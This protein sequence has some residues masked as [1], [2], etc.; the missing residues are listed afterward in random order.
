MVTAERGPVQL[1]GKVAV[2]TGAGSGI[3]A[4]TAM[5]LAALGA[6]VCCAGRTVENVEQTAEKI[7]AGGGEAF[8]LR[9]DVTS[10]ADNDEMVRETVARYGAVHIAHLNAGTGHWAGI[11]DYPLEEWDRTMAV[12]LRGVM[13]GLQAAGRAMRDAG[14]GSI[15]ITS[16]AAGLTGARMSTAYAASKH[17]VIGLAKSAAL[18]LGSVGI[19]V[20]TVC[21]GYIASNELMAQMGEELDLADRFPL[22]R[23]GRSEEVADLVAFLAGDHAAFITGSVFTIDGGWLAGGIDLHDEPADQATGDERVAALANANAPYPAD[24]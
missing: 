13:L 14:G 9:V 2:V 21:P 1:A 23:P 10:Q 20:N 7:R 16:S 24:S 11:L 17:G 19:R 22:R 8:G 18:E 12:N 3:G 4:A 5:T 15:V 6:R